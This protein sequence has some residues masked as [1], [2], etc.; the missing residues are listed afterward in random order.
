MAVV[1][2][3]AYGLTFITSLAIQGTALLTGII[4]ARLLEAAGRGDLAAIVLWPSII[5][6]LGLLG[7]RWAITREAAQP[8]GNIS[9]LL[10]NSVALSL[11]LSIFATGLGW[12]AV[13]W[14]LP[15]DKQHLLGDTRLF[16]LIIPL[17]IIN[18][19]L[20]ALDQGLLKW[21]RFN[22]LRVSYFGFYLIFLIFFWVVRIQ[23]VKW[24]VVAMLVSQVAPVTLRLLCQRQNFKSA[25]RVKEMLRLLRK[26]LPFFLASAA[27]MLS[28]QLDKA[29]V[30]GMLSAEMVGCY[31]VAFSIATIHE[32]IGITLGL[33]SF[34]ALANIPNTQQQGIYLGGIFRQATLVC[35]GMG[36]GVAALAPWLIVPVFGQSFAPA[37]KPTMVLVLAGSLIPLALILNQGL[38]GSGETLS[39]ILGRLLGCGILA[40]AAVLMVPRWGIVGMAWAAVL[41]A[42]GQLFFLVIAAAYFFKMPVGFF[43]GIRLQEFKL[44]WERLLSLCTKFLRFAY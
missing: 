42:A 9:N 7:T 26:S 43:W 5:A 28:L 32:S 3:R 23:Q 25:P 27:D 19:N 20:M 34:A 14:L 18:F 16:L 22:L 35:L 12:C 10:V 44:L 21:E 38:Y 39:S 33:T 15:H 8:S 30:I 13:P 24:F 31:F 36:L 41:G 40:T 6:I 4:T 11:V 17:T 37:V 1:T 29:M 2:H